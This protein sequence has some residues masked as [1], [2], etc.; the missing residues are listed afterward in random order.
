[1][2]R[3]LR[4][5]V[6]E[7]DHKR[8]LVLLMFFPSLFYWPASIGKEALMMLA[9]G[10]VSYGVALL[11][12]DKVRL[13]SILVFVGGVAGLVLIRPH[14][15]AL[16]VMALGVGSLVGT[17]RSARGG[18]GMKSVLVRII[19]LGVL[20]VVAIVVLSQTARFFGGED[21]SGGV[22]SALEKALDQTT[23]GGSSFEP[24]SVDNPAELPAGVITVFF[25]PFVWEADNGSTLF[26]AL[27]SLALLVVVAA[28]WRRL[29]GGVRL[30]LRRPYLVYVATFSSGF[31]L[32]FSYIGNFGILAR[33]RSVML[34]LVLA[35]LA[36]PPLA[37]G[38]GLLLS[39]TVHSD[40]EEAV[41]VE[42][43]VQVGAFSTE[44]G[45]A[46]IQPA[47]KVNT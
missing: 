3:S 12:S 9:L 13:A 38:R 42:S 39:K 16:A 33:Q 35:F 7:A 43:P 37:K 34:A 31:I 6:P 15:G 8:Y 23:T 18:A 21:S 11:L 26:A 1:M 44:L 10:V 14:Y 24:P 46:H 17:L 36:C 2:W 27:E 47:R 19:A 22:G 28:S 41:P 45:A 5:A 20:S 25:R 30:M 40:D 32:A 4:R 29:A